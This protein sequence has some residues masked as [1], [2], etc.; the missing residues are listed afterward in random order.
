MSSLSSSTPS[1][2][3]LTA[4]PNWGEKALYNE[5]ALFLDFFWYGEF[6]L[7][8]MDFSYE[9]WKDPEKKLGVLEWGGW[10]IRPTYLENKST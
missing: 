9:K 5:K 4:R 6:C 3:S 1:S 10:L 8:D 7:Q 2:S